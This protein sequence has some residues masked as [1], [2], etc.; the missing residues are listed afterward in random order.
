MRKIGIIVLL[1]ILTAACHPDQSFPQPTQHLIQSVTTV[2]Q[3]GPTSTSSPEL[4]SN[5]TDSPDIAATLS[6]G[7]PTEILQIFQSPDK[8]WEIRIEK[9]DCQKIGKLDEISLEELILRDQLTGVETQIYSQLINCGGVG[10]FGIG[11]SFWSKNSR[12]FYFTDAREGVPDGCCE[13]FW[14][15]PIARLDIQENKIKDLGI[16]AYSPDHY[17][18]ATWLNDGLTIWDLEQEFE[19]QFALFDDQMGVADIVWSPDNTS[20][21]YLQ[22]DSLFD[23]KKSRLVFLNL[24]KSNQFEL[25]TEDFPVFT[26]VVWTVSVQLFLTTPDGQKWVYTLSTKNLSNGY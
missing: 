4:N 8:K 22:V 20:L 6:A 26:D 3:I 10:A 9:I 18:L 12:Y 23:T 7:S 13:Y 21:V 15:Q 1:M 2:T 19:T 14:N 16:G 24:E 25:S 11:G 5:P 17:R